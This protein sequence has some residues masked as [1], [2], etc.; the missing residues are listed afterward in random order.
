MTGLN[1]PFFVPDASVWKL[2]PIPVDLDS[3]H[4]LAE[5]SWGPRPTEP[6]RMSESLCEYSLVRSPKN[7]K[8]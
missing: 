3:A 5:I 8:R 2:Q 1:K 6:E 4:R 7:P